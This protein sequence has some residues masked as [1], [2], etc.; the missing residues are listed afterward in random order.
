MAH[1]NSTPNYGLPQFVASDKPAWLTDINSAYADIDAG[2]HNAQTA[3][4]DAQDDATQ[5]LNDASSALT[6]ASSADAK[7]SGAI[8]SIAPI[9]DTAAVYSVGDRVIYNSLLYRCIVDV[10]VPG[11]WTGSANWT[12]ETI[13]SIVRNI[14]AKTGSD[15]PVSDTDSD[16]IASKIEP[17][18]DFIA[19]PLFKRLACNNITKTLP[20]NG[21]ATITGNE[22]TFSE[23][24]AGYTPVA[25]ASLYSTALGYFSVFDVRAVG[26]NGTFA[27]IRSTSGSSQ[28]TISNFTVLFARNDLL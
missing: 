6:T 5:A 28:N 4:D 8:A 24:I 27:I 7:A 21:S 25:I 15:I 13:N 12:R 16:S 11:P 17:L 22:V 1:S 20:A 9:F 26:T 18:S 2:M 14:D 23:S 10:N 3:A 19:T